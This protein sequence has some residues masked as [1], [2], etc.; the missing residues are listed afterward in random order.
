I[1]VIIVGGLQV[2]NGTLDW[3]ELLAF[4]MALRATQAP[5][6]NL[7][8]YYLDIQRHAASV[9]QIDA[10]LRERPEIE[11]RP[12]ARPLL[13]PPNRVRGDHISF[14]IN[15]APIL[16]DVSFELRAGETL[17]VVGASGSGK[18][19]LLN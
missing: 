12:D 6:N 3:P 7:N 14:S 11:D 2:L 4:L 17:G 9:A 18:T 19:T 8:S 5:V 15:S 10:L 13:A 16:E 1:I